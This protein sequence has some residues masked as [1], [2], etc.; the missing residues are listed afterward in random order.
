MIDAKV[1]ISLSS[2]DIP[3][4]TDI[5]NNIGSKPNKPPDSVLTKLINVF[6]ISTFARELPKI[7]G[8]CNVEANPSSNPAATM[9]DKGPIKDLPSF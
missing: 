6:T 9:I 7:I 1:A 2:L 3:I 5:Q 4:A 8:F